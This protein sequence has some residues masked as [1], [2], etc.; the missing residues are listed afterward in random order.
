[1]TP[2]VQITLITTIGA[3]LVALIGS[4]ILIHHH[5][6]KKSAKESKDEQDAD[7]N[8]PDITQKKPVRVPDISEPLKADNPTREKPIPEPP[9]KPIVIPEPPERPIVIPDP[10]EKPIVIRERPAKPIV[11]PDIPV[12]S[13]N[14]FVLDPNKQEF[15]SAEYVEALGSLLA[16][17][18]GP[19]DISIKKI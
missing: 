3:V 6:K 11:I 14:P 17:N 19:G 8:E 10:P 9:A 18:R 15:G 1:M 5:K 4:P 16:G 13:R 12:D 2:E 7:V